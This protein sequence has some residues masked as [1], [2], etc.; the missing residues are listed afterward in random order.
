MQPSFTSN[1]T[2]DERQNGCDKETKWV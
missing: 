2:L 1:V